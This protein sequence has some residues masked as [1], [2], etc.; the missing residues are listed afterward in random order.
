MSLGDDLKVEVKKIFRTRWESRKG[1]VVPQSENLQFSN[2]SVLIE[3]TIL[4]AD[5][6]GSTNMVDRYKPEFAAEIYKSYLYSA[7]KIIRLQGGSIASYDGDRIMAVFIGK[8]KNSDAANTALKINYAVTKIINP[9]IEE[10][11]P[12]STFTVKQ[13]V[14]IDTSDLLVART[15]IRGSND[16]VWVGRAAN[17][18]H[19]K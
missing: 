14:G 1:Q 3:G 12:K 4:Y 5:L 13:V 11:Y 7:A 9:A 17:Y 8:S 18:R 19:L 6:D 10:C 16:L 15:G 2:K